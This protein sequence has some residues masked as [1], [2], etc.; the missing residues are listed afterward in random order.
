MG[1]R[2]LRTDGLSPTFLGWMLD[3]EFA[4]CQVLS[5]SVTNTNWLRLTTNSK[6]YDFRNGILLDGPFLLALQ[7]TQG[8]GRLHVCLIFLYQPNQARQK[9]TMIILNSADSTEWLPEARFQFGDAG[10]GVKIQALLLPI[11]DR[12][13]IFLGA[14]TVTDHPCFCFYGLEAMPWLS[15]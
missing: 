4:M 7:E 9:Q 15:L 6:I 12:R 5:L 8:D 2:T 13:C 3:I 10:Y 11:V 14:W 1:R